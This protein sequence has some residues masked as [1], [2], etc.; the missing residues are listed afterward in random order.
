MQKRLYVNRTPGAPPT[1][2][3]PRD[4]VKIDF[5]KRLQ[6]AMVKKGWNQSE[7][8][9]RSSGYLK[10]GEIGRDLISHYIRGVAIPQPEKLQALCKA[11]GVEPV[12][13]LPTAP[14]VDNKSPPF[15]MRQLEDGNVWLRINQA[16]SMDQALRIGKIL[17]E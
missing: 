15:D 4:A 6:R 12:D 8:A 3:T 7:L 14:T 11:L 1:K 10:G 13:L 5:A 9:R 17:N 2:G 16:V